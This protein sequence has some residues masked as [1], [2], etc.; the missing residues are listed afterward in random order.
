LSNLNRFLNYFIAEKIKQIAAR[1]IQYLPP[2][3][4]HVAALLCEV[5]DSANMLQIWKKM[6]TEYLDFA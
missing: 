4:Q 5:I 3:L 2:H 6:Q 1:V